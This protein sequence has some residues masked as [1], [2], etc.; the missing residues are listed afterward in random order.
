MSGTLFLIFVVLWSNR[1]TNYVNFAIDQQ[2]GQ[3]LE[4]MEA[5]KN[6]GEGEGK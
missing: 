2:L 3:L 1:V 5:L 6:D 4:L